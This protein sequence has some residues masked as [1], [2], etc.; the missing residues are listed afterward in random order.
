[1][2]ETLDDDGALRRQALLHPLSVRSFVVA[3]KS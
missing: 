2:I 1:M 3:G